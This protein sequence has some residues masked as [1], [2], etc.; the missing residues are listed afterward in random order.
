MLL[1]SPVFRFLRL[2]PPFWELAY[3]I[4][5]STGSFWDWNPSPPEVT[6]Q[7]LVRI[8]HGLEV[9][10]GPHMEKLS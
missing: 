4:W 1:D 10:E 8:P 9:R 2:T 5:W 3:T 7:S 6:N